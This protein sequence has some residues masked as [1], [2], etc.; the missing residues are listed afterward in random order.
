MRLFV[1][2]ELPSQVLDVL[3]QG[4]SELKR[5]LP[6]ARWVRAGA[7][8]I[9]LKFL[10]EQNESLLDDL[11]HCAPAGLSGFVPVPIRL[12]GGGFF[13]DERRARVAW[14]GGQAP[15]LEGWA[16][17]IEECAASFGVPREPRK[18]S[19]HL[20]LARLERPWGPRTVEDFMVRVGKWRVPE[21]EARELVL[22]KSDL[23][24]SG[25]EY[26]AMRRW[27]V[28]GE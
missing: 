26:S 28:G 22:F 18:F 23:K 7:L 10:G 25:P 1:A 17:V 8:H 13:P 19:L 16:G 20:T 27:R 21:F 24:P 11:D 15:G 12:G 4:L 9:T 14:I 6:P 5:D 2:V 3:T